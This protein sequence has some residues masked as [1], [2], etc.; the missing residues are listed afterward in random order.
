MRWRRS[1]FRF[2]SFWNRARSPFRLDMLP[3]VAQSRLRDLRV[4][5]YELPK[6]KNLG[7]A[8]YGT[9]SD[10]CHKGWPVGAQIVGSEL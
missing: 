4:R 1:I 9:R 8:G 6:R 5:W 3:F 7:G 2:R 10:R